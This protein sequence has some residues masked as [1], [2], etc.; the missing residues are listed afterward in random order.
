MN[1]NSRPLVITGVVALVIACVVGLITFLVYEG[2]AYGK[3]DGGH[4]A[5][6]RNGGPFDN[7]NIRQVLPANSGR[8]NIGYLS[9]L[10]NYPTSQRFFT[11]SS[12][13]NADANESVT[14]PTADGV[15]VG[16]EGTAYFTLNTSSEN[17]Y[18]VIKD[19]DNKY[20]TR[21]F[22][23]VPAGSKNSVT[24]HVYDGDQGFSCFL[25]QIVSPVINNDLRAAI[26]DLKCADLVASC[27]LVQNTTGQI[28]TSKIGVANVNLAKIESAISTS[29][30]SDLNTTLG[31]NYVQGVHFNLGKVD[32]P[33]AVQDAIDQAQSAFAGVTKSEAALKQA[34]IDAQTNEARQ[35][36]YDLCKTCAQ[37]DILGALP[38]GITVYAPGGSNNLALPTGN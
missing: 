16:I 35:K 38:K 28:D 26:G 10:H 12:S 8:T 21:T 4:V 1:E 27:S 23:C 25:D 30:Q 15:S 7:T 6:V 34:Q 11:I 33:T 36:G 2:E 32:L 20:G 17:N 29:L 18:A 9:T 3:T 14:V 24:K 13:G 5:V 22:T 37:I 31:G 19:F